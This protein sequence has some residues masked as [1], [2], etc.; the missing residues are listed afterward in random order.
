MIDVNKSRWNAK[1]LKATS[2]KG[3]IPQNDLLIKLLIN[4]SPVVEAAIDY[5]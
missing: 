3:I 5:D 2:G 1:V 4:G